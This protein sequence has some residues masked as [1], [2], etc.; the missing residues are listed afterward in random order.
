MSEFVLLYRST[1]EAHEAVMGSPEKARENMAKWRVW[2][3]DMTAKGQ[4]KNLGLPLVRT[5][6]VVRG[7]VKSVMDGPY[8]E[9]KEVVGGFSII[10][11][12]DPTHAAEIASACP[13]VALGGSVEVRPV[14]ALPE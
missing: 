9:T 1:N 12:R 14:M 6:K 11:A 8:A 5:G 2:F 4:L 13:I 3:D 7:P 10:E